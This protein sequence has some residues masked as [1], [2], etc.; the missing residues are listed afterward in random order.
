MKQIK[1]VHGGFLALTAFLLI[2][3]GACANTHKNPLM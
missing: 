1:H 3:I 2:F